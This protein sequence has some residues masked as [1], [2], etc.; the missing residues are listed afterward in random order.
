[1][2]VIEESSWLSPKRGFRISD[3]G[4]R[5]PM[6]QVGGE[7]VNRKVFD[8]VPGADFNNGRAWAMA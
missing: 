6:Q 1:M 8:I 2:C 7:E 5:D 4:G 3:H